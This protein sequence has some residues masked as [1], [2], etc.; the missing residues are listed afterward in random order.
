MK[1]MLYSINLK[2]VSKIYS[3]LNH[4]R[5]QSLY[6]LFIKCKVN[7]IINIIPKENFNN[8]HYIPFIFNNK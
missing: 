1:N 5:N 7:Y 8:N 2:S 6:N 4:A 3:K